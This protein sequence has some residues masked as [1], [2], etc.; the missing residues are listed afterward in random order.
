[1]RLTCPQDDHV[2]VSQPAPRGVYWRCPAC[3]GRAVGVGLLRRSVAREAV[4]RIWTAARESPRRPGRRCPSCL[5]SMAEVRADVGPAVDVCLSCQLVWFD[6]REYEQIPPAPAADEQPLPPAAREVLATARAEAEAARPPRQFGWDAPEQ[7]WKYLPALLG[8]PVEYDRQTFRT[9]PW[10]TWVLVAFITAF[11]LR[12]MADLEYAVRQFGLIP[13]QWWRHGGLTLLTSFL[14]HGGIFHLLGNMY[15][16]LVFGDN[17]E[18]VLGKVRY[19]A[20]ILLAAAAGDAAHIALDP[21]SEV[22]LIGAS[23][24]ISGVIAFYALQFPR[25]RLGVLFRIFLIYF[26]WVRM[27]AYAYVGVWILLQVVGAYLQ[28]TGATSVSALAHL[29]GVLVGAGFWLAY[30]RG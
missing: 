6:A 26:R 8:M 30:R 5:R 23:G 20:L 14:L 18:D 27:P 7:L 28:L 11:S 29:G 1:M 22:P 21:R 4:T 17:V 12:A 24:G 13:A 25:A 19:L 2:L 10:M 15:F 3:G 9:V 16:L